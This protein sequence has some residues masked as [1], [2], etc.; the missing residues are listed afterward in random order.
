MTADCPT[1]DRT[2]DATA[3]FC[4]ACG[5]RLDTGLLQ[6]TRPPRPGGERRTRHPVLWSALGLVL[7]TAMAVT[8]PVVTIDRDTAVSGEVG[9]PDTDRVPTRAPTPRRR[10]ATP[11]P[12]PTVQCHGPGGEAADCVRWVQDVGAVAAAATEGVFGAT[13]H[14][15]IALNYAGGTVTAVNVA[16]GTRHWT[17]TFAAPLQMAAADGDALLVA[18]GGRAMLLSLTTG[19]QRWEVHTSDRLYGDILTGTLALTVRRPSESGTPE[20]VARNRDDGGVRWT[21]TATSDEPLMVSA[22]GPLLVSQPDTQTVTAVAATTGEELWQR[23]GTLRHDAS[24]DGVAVLYEPIPTSEQPPPERSGVRITVVDV[25]DGTVS[26]QRTFRGLVEFADD[27]RLMIVTSERR[28]RAHDV[29]TGAL[30]WDV[31]TDERETPARETNWATEGTPADV[32]VTV[33]PGGLLRGRDL[34]DGRIRWRRAATSGG[35]SRAIVDG[36]VMQVRNGPVTQLRDTRT[37]DLLLTY[38]GDEW[39]LDVDL[40]AGLYLSPRSG[41]M[42]RLALPDP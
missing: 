17:R 14:R 20:L 24:P 15:G 37:G 40:D 13:V 29:R 26:W 16:T 28:L 42:L 33:S 23:P 38:R 27:A 25:D 9:V 21:W 30:V 41:R 3:A 10:Q 22:H 1:C 18:A 8:V 12:A 34:R 11:A 5:E 31:R 36:Q 39:L 6:P 32:L 4:G 19:E 7:V 2:W 35:D